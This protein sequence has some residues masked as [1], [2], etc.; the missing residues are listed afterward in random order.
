MSTILF[1]SQRLNVMFTLYIDQAVT[2]TDTSKQFV[3]F[4]ITPKSW[5]YMK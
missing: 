2:I 4:G 1:N 3:F 5:P